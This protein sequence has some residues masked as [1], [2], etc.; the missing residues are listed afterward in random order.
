[1]THQLIITA[2]DY[3]MC[4]PVNTAIEDCLAAGAMRATCVMANMPLWRD[5]AQLRQRFPDASI[6]LHWT[7]TQGSPVLPAEKVPSLVDN[8]GNFRSFAALRSRALRQQVNLDEVQAEL[9]AQYVRF[10]E[11]AGAPDFWNTHENIHVSPGLFGVFV[12]VGRELCIPVMRCQ[13]RI[14]APST[15][16]PEGYVLRHPFYWLKGLVIAYW[17]ARAER[18]G[19]LMPD[20]AIH[21]PGYRAGETRIEDAL[22]RVP[23]AKIQRAAEL[24]IHPA[25][26]VDRE[27]FGNVTES[28]VRD[29]QVFRDPG[30][31]DRLLKAGVNPVGFEVLHGK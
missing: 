29:Y 14:T 10:F 19:M 21:T 16:T 1:M 27:L 18:L 3:G 22:K 31:K 2:D 20:G 12:R 17:S 9:I 26:M 28:R 6:G 30:L 4:A 23:W 11:V 24:I 5:A 25:T 8:T 13:R 15:G 7:L